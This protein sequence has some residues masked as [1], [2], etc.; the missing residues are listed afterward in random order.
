[1]HHCPQC[2]YA[3]GP[4]PGVPGEPLGT[5]TADVCCP[6]CSRVVPRGSR[7]VVGSSVEEAMQPITNWRRRY[8]VLAALGPG[9][10]LA[11][12][13]SSVVLALFGVGRSRGLGADLLGLLML[14]AA[15][16][17]LVNA[18]RRWNAKGD[19]DERIPASWEL[20]WLVSPGLVTVFDRTLVLKKA[21]AA[22]E[23][24]AENALVTEVRAAQ[25]QDIRASAPSR[26]WYR[27]RVGRR[28]VALLT[29]H[30]LKIGRDG[31]RAGVDSRSI[32]ADV[33]GPSSGGAVDHEEAVLAAGGRVAAD[34]RATLGTVGV[35]D[36]PPGAPSAPAPAAD[37]GLLVLRGPTHAMLP[38]PQPRSRIARQLM[39]PASLGG[40]LAAIAIGLVVLSGSAI[41]QSGFLH[42]TAWFGGTLFAVTIAIGVV[43]ARRALRRSLARSL[44]AVRSDGVEVT[45]EVY[46]SVRKA[47]EVR[48][49]RH[50]RAAIGSVAIRMEFGM[51]L[52]MLRASDGSLLA[53]ISPEAMDPPDGEAFAR[54]V[55]GVLGIV[56]N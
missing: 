11:I 4:L 18:W 49:T 20:Q 19:G 47:P 40:L 5:F 33:G 51:P 42:G 37:P 21:G 46:R 29:L 30:E 3:F 25:I 1:M 12:Q 45:E 34:L 26:S 41:G 54:R 17:L 28:N 16:S 24:A 38:W 55:N 8:L 44:W 22:S 15:A 6:E 2:D 23:D 35:V 32:Y 27:R 10:V 7:I 53:T 50:P 39:V 14:V 13:G 31:A 9:I 36:A 56:G 52:L 48:M 43:R